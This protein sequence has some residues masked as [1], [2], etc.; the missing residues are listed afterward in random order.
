M[1]IVA[2]LCQAG[3]VKLGLFLTTLVIMVGG[4]DLYFEQP[5]NPNSTPPT[6]IPP[7]ATPGA[8][9]ASFFTEP[10]DTPA[11]NTCM[12]PDGDPSYSLPS[13]DGELCVCGSP[14][15]RIRAG[16]I[17]RWHGTTSNPWTGAHDV[18]FVF[19]ASGAYS[20]DAAGINS[21]TYYG[22]DMDNPAKVWSL[23]DL[24]A[25]GEAVG[26]M[27]VWWESAGTVQEGELDSIRVS[28]DGTQLGFRFWRT[29]AGRYGPIEYDLQRCE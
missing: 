7:D 2:T 24:L 25:N 15:E 21:A 3:L 19:L 9:D 16:M 28:E 11:D 6:P 1:R 29:W 27:T 8:P 17:G 20:A 14:L 23:T 10:C 5:S 26:R 4:C 13:T 12:C 22:S 18:W